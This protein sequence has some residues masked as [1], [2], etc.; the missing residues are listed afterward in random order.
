VERVRRSIIIGVCTEEKQAGPFRADHAIVE[1]RKFPVNMRRHRDVTDNQK[2][3]LSQS[4]A[5][6]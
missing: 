4:S 1:E 2:I 6:G 3:A 5:R